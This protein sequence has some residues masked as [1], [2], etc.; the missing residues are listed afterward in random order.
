MIE[1]ALIQHRGGALSFETLLP[2]SHS[3]ARKPPIQDS[4]GNRDLPPL[5]EMTVQHIRQ[6]LEM[7]GGKI[8]GPGGAA[9]ILRL[10]PNTLRN[11]MNKLGIP[12]GKK[13]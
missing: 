3:G 1:R 8:N 12:Y 5:D 13:S 4:G 7:A 10:H 6:A 11:R 2:V 9:Q